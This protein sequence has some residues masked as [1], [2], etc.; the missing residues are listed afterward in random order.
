VARTDDDRRP[1]AETNEQ[2]GGFVFI[3]ATDLNE[4]ARREEFEPQPPDP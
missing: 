3:Q 1:F 4:V 2:L